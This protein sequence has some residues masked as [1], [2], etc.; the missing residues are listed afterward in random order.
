[1]KL[2]ELSRVAGE[3]SNVRWPALL[4]AIMGSLHCWTVHGK[5]YGVLVQFG[6]YQHRYEWTDFWC[7]NTVQLLPTATQ[8]ILLQL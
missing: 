8:A 2:A 1:M 5:I 3:L 4:T 6:Y 7:S